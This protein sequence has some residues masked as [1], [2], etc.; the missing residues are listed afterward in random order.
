MKKRNSA[1]NIIPI[2]LVVLAV[3][4]IFYYVG[5]FS[6]IVNLFHEPALTPDIACGNG[7]CEYAYEDVST[8]AQDCKPLRTLKSSEINESGVGVAIYQFYSFIFNSAR[9]TLNGPVSDSLPGE[10]ISN[11]P[12]TLLQISHQSDLEF[13]INETKN[14]GTKWVRVE[15]DWSS[16]EWP[17]YT[18]SPGNIP[19]PRKFDWR[20]TDYLVENFSKVNISIQGALFQESTN[21]LRVDS[22]TDEINRDTWECRAPKENLY[23]RDREGVPEKFEGETYMDAWL[24]F[25]NAS[26]SRYKGKINYWSV[27]IE[28]L[29]YPYCPEVNIVGTSTDDY[30]NLLC[31]TYAIIKRE[32]PEATVISSGLNGN[33]LDEDYK[34]FFDKAYGCFDVLAIHTY[35]READEYPEAS[36]DRALNYEERINR[37][38]GLMAEYGEVKPIWDSEVGYLKPDSGQ[39]DRFENE[40]VQSKYTLR[41][42]IQNLALGINRMN[43]FNF[44]IPYR[45]NSVAFVKHALIYNTMS[46]GNID[47]PCNSGI[48][49]PAFYSYG[50]IASIFNNKVQLASTSTSS[51]L[52]KNIKIPDYSLSQNLLNSHELEVWKDI[53]VSDGDILLFTGYANV[54]STNKFHTPEFQI[55]IMQGNEVINLTAIRRTDGFEKFS[56]T[57]NISSGY[58]GNLK[59]RIHAFY[60]KNVGGNIIAKEIEA[61]KVIGSSKNI[62]FFY[63]PY[64]NTIGQSNEYYAYL[65]INKE[66]KFIYAYWVGIKS[67]DSFPDVKT[68]IEINK[69]LTNPVLVNMYTG[70]V[71]DLRAINYEISNGRTIFKNMPLRDYPILIAEKETIPL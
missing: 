64:N 13:V 71:W 25:V 30:A 16:I 34:K 32:N 45:P 57:F 26:V 69:V 51:I 20:Y 49:R 4:I 18:I 35:L 23:V 47:S 70:E 7:F 6:F 68:N 5:F 9:V 10:D 60:P 27:G 39:P 15:F 61:R 59:V 41:H 44:A 1:K 65:F 67:E 3:L 12:Y 37:L 52:L 54:I 42:Y 62:S 11:D 29:N 33:I 38:K 40:V 48:K 43:Y 63:F 46:C 55:Q 36:P 14:M 8:C 53:S 58:T 17:N 66:G 2:A 31:K 19:S 22:N 28:Y 50:Y 56:R 21:P 24:R